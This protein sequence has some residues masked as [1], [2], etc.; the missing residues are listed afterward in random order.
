MLASTCS[1]RLA[2]L[3]TVKFLSRLLTPLKRLPSSATTARVNRLNWRHRTTNWAQAER[4]AAPLSQSASS[5]TPTQSVRILPQPTFSHSLGPRAVIGGAEKECLR[6]A[7]SEPSRE[8]PGLPVSVESRC[9]A[10]TLG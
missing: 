5:K 4:I 3:A 1:I 9:G 6:R 8:H 2:T 7:E 10:V